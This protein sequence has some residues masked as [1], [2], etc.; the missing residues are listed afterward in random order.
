MKTKVGT[1]T[2]ARSDAAIACDIRQTLKL[3]NDVP[4][5]LIGAQVHSGIVMLEGTVEANLQKEAAEADA[6]KVKGVR[7]V[8]SRI[9]L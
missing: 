2:H 1:Q 9:H 6:Q 8:T 7:G 4:D 5:E 3:D